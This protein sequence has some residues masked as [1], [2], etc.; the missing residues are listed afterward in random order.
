MMSVR[1]SRYRDRSGI[2]HLISRTTRA[3]LARPTPRVAPGCGL[4]IGAPRAS[5]F[6]LSRTCRMRLRKRHGALRLALL[7]PMMACAPAHAGTASAA[8]DGAPRAE[9]AAMLERSARAWNRG[10]LD[11][12]VGDYLDS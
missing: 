7:A 8:P 6:A 10:D 12:F 9:I 1:S 11:A 4:P 5:F 2:D 3:G